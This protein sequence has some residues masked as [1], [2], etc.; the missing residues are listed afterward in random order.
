MKKSASP[1]SKSLKTFFVYTAI[2][3][4]FIFISLAVKAFFVIRA[5]KFDG[6]HQFLLSVKQNQ[7]VKQILAFDPSQSKVSVL[8]LKGDK[9]TPSMADQQLGFIPDATVDMGDR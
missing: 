3:L 7:A 6:H 4:F 8:D 9:A 5:S 2:V 1:Q